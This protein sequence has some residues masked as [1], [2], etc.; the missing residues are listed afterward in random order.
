MSTLHF[1]SSVYVRDL[2]RHGIISAHHHNPRSY[3]IQTDQGKIRRNR[4]LLIEIQPGTLTDDSPGAN[5]EDVASHL[6]TET[7]MKLTLETAP[8]S[9][10]AD[11]MDTQLTDRTTSPASLSTATKVSESGVH[12]TA[13]GASPW[14]TTRAGRQIRRPQRLDY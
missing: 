12:S 9:S 8:G 14:Y 11:G 4:S 6:E 13:I 7:P 1:S 5:Q 3:L 2:D 10:N